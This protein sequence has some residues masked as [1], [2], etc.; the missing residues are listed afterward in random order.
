MGCAVLLPGRGEVL[1]AGLIQGLP[2][3][4]RGLWAQVVVPGTEP[5]MVVSWHA[6]NAASDGRQDKMTADAAMHRWLAGAS[7]PLVVGT[8]LNTWTDPVDLQPPDPD[9]PFYQEHDFVGAAARHGLGDAYRTVV[10]DRGEL[11]RLRTERPFGPLAVSHV[12][13]GGDQHRMD[14]ILVSPDLCSVDA[15]YCY[16][17]AVV[18]GSDHALHWAD[19]TLQV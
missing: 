6:P 5:V 12:L 18:A 14:R 17:D 11:D 16:D 3:T 8:D 13:P 2:K 9:H 10:A 7:W 1:A 4:Q 19:L 15:G